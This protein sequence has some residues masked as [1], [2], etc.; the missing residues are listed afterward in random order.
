[1]DNGGNI[2]NN[3]TTNSLYQQYNF[4][5]EISKNQKYLQDT[6]AKLQETAKQAPAVKSEVTP[7]TQQKMTEHLTQTFGQLP[8]TE[9]TEGGRRQGPPK[10]AARPDLKQ[11]AGESTSAKAP[12]LL[13][14]PKPPPVKI[15]TPEE[16]AARFDKEV[17][18]LL[19]KLKIPATEE[20]KEMAKTMILFKAQ[21]EEKQMRKLVST[22]AE[23]PN[24]GGDEKKSACFL[25]ANKLPVTKESITSTTRYLTTNSQIGD[26]L[27]EIRET[28]MKI[29]GMTRN[30][31]MRTVFTRLAGVMGK[32]I[33]RPD[34]HAA[35]EMK[36]TL[37]KLAQA[38]GVEK[39]ISKVMFRQ[40]SSDANVKMDQRMI[41]S[42]TQQTDFGKLAN[43]LSSLADKF[44]A[45][46][47]EKALILSLVDG[48]GRLAESF[49]GAGLVNEAG[50]SRANE[51]AP[52]FCLINVPMFL[53][54]GVSNGKLVITFQPYTRNVDP[55]NVKI[56]FRIQTKTLGFMQFI[57][58][59]INNVVQGNVFVE[60][61][62]VKELVEK[63]ITDF[64]KALLAQLYQIKYISCDAVPEGNIKFLSE[65]NFDTLGVLT[66]AV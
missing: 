23:F 29:A 9:E 11:S 34:A 8:G 27:V 22:L 55:E 44:Q 18:T 15:P 42:L 24:A 2:F 52:G 48:V 61:E 6:V 43:T 1:M 32:F 25:H 20:N 31:R 51:G 5:S 10:E 65:L 60:S 35:H 58:N 59:I 36:V 17:T 30:R 39:D 7:E 64:K 26:R 54:D 47:A 63:N 40:V 28:A 19:T 49:A 53:K 33:A 3:F 41:D 38:L 4:S 46:G 45:A 12:Q 57:L 13:E 14:L 16:A 66:N 37:F 21:V 62:K 50:M 56:D